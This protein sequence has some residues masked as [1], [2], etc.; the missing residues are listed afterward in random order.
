MPGET[1]IGA[2]AKFGENSYLALQ[3]TLMYSD[4]MNAFHRSQQKSYHCLSTL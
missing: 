3:G 1:V 4:T 2:V